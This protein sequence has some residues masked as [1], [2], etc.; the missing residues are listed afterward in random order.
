M[1]TF[2]YDFCFLRHSWLE[3][4]T[5]FDVTNHSLPPDDEHV[6]CDLESTLGDPKAV[7]YQILE[8]AAHAEESINT[9]VAALDVLQDK[10]RK[11]ENL[12]NSRY[13]GPLK[14]VMEGR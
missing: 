13:G 6:L 9:A 11:A 5:F 12:V 2:R 4:L 1:N 10:L 7:A 8:N 3:T 14:A